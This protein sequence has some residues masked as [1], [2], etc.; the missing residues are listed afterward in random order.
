MQKI[1]NYYLQSA[2]SFHVRGSIHTRSTT[3]QKF[4]SMISSF[5]G[6]VLGLNQDRK[7]FRAFH[8]VDQCAGKRKTVW[9]QLTQK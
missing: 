9:A 6:S 3:F 4:A 1:L 5:L 8:I 7:V 2:A